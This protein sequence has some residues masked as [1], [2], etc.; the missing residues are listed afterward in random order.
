MP[1]LYP[2]IINLPS[3]FWLLYGNRKKI[4]PNRCFQLQVIIFKFLIVLQQP[5]VRKGNYCVKYF[6]IQKL[7]FT[8]SILHTLHMKTCKNVLNLNIIYFCP[9][10]MQRTYSNIYQLNIYLL[11]MDVYNIRIYSHPEE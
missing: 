8:Y 3:K 9:I 1:R 2:P 4:T 11:K 10:G 6:K 7:V 5:S